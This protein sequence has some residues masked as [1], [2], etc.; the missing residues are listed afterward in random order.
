MIR[1]RNVTLRAGRKVL[2]E[3]VSLEVAAG[4][5]VAVTGPN[6]AG[7]S[8]LLR[9][10]AGELAPTEGEVCYG[11][12]PLAEWLP[13]AIARVRGVLPQDASLSFPFRAGEVVL[14]GR[15]PHLHGTERPHDLA[16][17]HAAM[18][19]TGVAHLADRDYTRLS[20]GERQRVHLARVLAQIWDA[21][22]GGGRALLLDEPTSSLDPAHQH[23]TL[24]RAV[25]FAR[26]GAAVLVILH[27]LN[28]AAQYADRM[29]VMRA[30]R[31]L[32]SG[33][34]GEVLQPSLIRDAFGFEA[35]VTPHP[36]L[37][38]PVVI[39]GTQPAFPAATRST[40]P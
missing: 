22:S 7:K 11:G 21:P 10:L 6:G 9:C 20:G 2:V 12:R 26:E 25:A 35:L 37:P 23:L 32:A 36:T 31:M 17:V 1:L 29:V 5:V 18:E 27:D 13:A 24:Q 14:M 28:L 8:S 34:P 16:I 15:T 40:S 30:G 33:T 19:A 3:D 4:E 38:V 39:A